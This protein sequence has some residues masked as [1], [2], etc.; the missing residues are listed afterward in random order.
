MGFFFV[1]ELPRSA[2][3][4]APLWQ[5]ETNAPPHPSTATPCDWVEILQS[6][7]IHVM[8]R[9][10]QLGFSGTKRILCV[11]YMCS[12]AGLFW[13][14]CASAVVYLFSALWEH[15]ER[16]WTELHVQVVAQ[17]DSV[18]VYIF[19]DVWCKIKCIL[20]FVIKLQPILFHDVTW[21]KRRYSNS[22]HLQVAIF[23]CRVDLFWSSV[24]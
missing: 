7:G 14:R 16:L 15:R 20:S 4:I 2:C 13:T 12:S 5:A 18:F 22:V 17:P 3:H 6:A 11:P 1:S 8:V 9:D 10:C 19:Y 24:F 21:N 23:H